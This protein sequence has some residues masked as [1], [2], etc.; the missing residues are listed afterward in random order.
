MPL[1]PFAIV[2]R[3]RPLILVFI[4]ARDSRTRVRRRSPVLVYLLYCFGLSLLIARQRTRREPGDPA[5]RGG[6]VEADQLSRVK[7]K[8]LCRP[9][10]AYR[11]LAVREPSEVS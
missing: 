8:G 10:A 5:V 7:L 2:S 4:I 6:L 9:S 3:Q 11:V 1:L